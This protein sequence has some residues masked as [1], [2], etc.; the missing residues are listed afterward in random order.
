MGWKDKGNEYCT[1]NDCSLVNLLGEGGKHFRWQCGS[2]HI[3]GYGNTLEFGDD[4]ESKKGNG[5]WGKLRGKL[6][7]GWE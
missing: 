1:E 3:E 2:D 6:S 7:G 5:R 4:G